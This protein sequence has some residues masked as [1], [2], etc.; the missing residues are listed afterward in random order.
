MQLRLHAN[1]TTTP[2]T[3]AYIQQSAASHAALAR[4]LGMEPGPELGGLL[5]EL[6][7]AAFAGETGTREQAVEVARRLRQ[8]RG[9]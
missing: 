3:R 1:A 8:N 4:E 7:E 2:R 6:S 9:R 5:A